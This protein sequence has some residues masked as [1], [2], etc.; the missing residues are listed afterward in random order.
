MA[1]TILIKIRNDVWIGKRKA[2]S[3]LGDDMTERK[4][5]NMLFVLFLI[6]LFTFQNIQAQ[7]LEEL[8]LFGK[9]IFVDAG[10][11][12]R[13]PGAMYG[14]LM[15]KDLNLAMALTLQQTLL[16]QGAIVY[17]TRDEDEDLSSKWDESLKRGDLY[18]RI[19]MYR[20]KNADLYLSIHMNDHENETQSGA[21]VLYNKINPENERLGTILM[22]LFQKEL[23]S[24][25][26]L[27]TTDL[28]MYRNTTVPGVLIEC[29]FIS[30]ANDRYLLQKKSYQEKISQIITKGVITFFQHS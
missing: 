21:E 18:R 5:K 23:H 6:G 13:D 14:N 2:Y 1:P 8:P 27:K 16:E 15:E 19:V 25:R 20:K 7:V 30:N 3:L 28:Y 9:I 26:K 10:H 17:M 29:G 4:I 11:G 24:K 22:N 12:G